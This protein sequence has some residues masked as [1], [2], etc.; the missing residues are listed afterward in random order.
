MFPWR[1]L[2]DS[3]LNML[4][5]EGCSV[6]TGID[7]PRAGD[8]RSAGNLPPQERS[9]PEILTHPSLCYPCGDNLRSVPHSLSEGADG[10][11]TQ[12]PTAVMCSL[13]T[14]PSFPLSLPL[15]HAASWAHLPNKMLTRQSFMIYFWTI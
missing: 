4:T 2:V 13:A 5:P 9:S 6:H 12:R 1:S 11:E 7:L 15:L 3:F 8:T 10:N 14:L